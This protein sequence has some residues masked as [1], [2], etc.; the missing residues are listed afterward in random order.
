MYKL[1]AQR[2][3]S[4]FQA[5][6]V[7]FAVMKAIDSIMVFFR[8]RNHI[9]SKFTLVGVQ[10]MTTDRK[11]FQ[12]L[13]FIPLGYRAMYAPRERH[14]DFDIEKLRIQQLKEAHFKRIRTNIQD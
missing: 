13:Y 2:I 6:T 9:H 10:V 4:L 12:N 1:F 14:I 3:A 11:H 8:C 7:I 5:P